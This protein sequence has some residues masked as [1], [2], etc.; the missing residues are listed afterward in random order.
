MEKQ[1]IDKILEIIKNCS[2]HDGWAQQA[3]VCSQCKKE[4]IDLKELGGTKKVFTLLEK[5]KNIEVSKDSHEL[6]ILKVKEENNM[7]TIKSKKD[8]KGLF[9]LGYV[10]NHPHS[11][12][13]D[14]CITILS[15]IAGHEI[16]LQKVD[17][18]I[19]SNEFKLEYFDNENNHVPNETEALEKS[20]MLPIKDRNN[21]NI[22]GVFSR[23]TLHDNFTGVIWQTTSIGGLERYG[24]INSTSIE[25]FKRIAQNKEITEGNIMKYIIDKVEYR[26]GGGYAK[27]PDGK[28]VTK[29]NGKYAIFQTKLKTKSKTPIIGI[30]SK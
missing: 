9:K 29:E 27:F 5:T 6:P 2:T 18:F 11:R 19:E 15:K 1:I 8:K 20:F 21:G 16:S 10:A 17:E 25:E 26:N 24:K 14:N 23:Q 3:K 28:N 30:F 13:E 4:G 12:K 7:D 22:Y